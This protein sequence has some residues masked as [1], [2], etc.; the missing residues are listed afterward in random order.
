[1]ADLDRQ[2]AARRLGV[3]E[4]EVV[5]IRDE[6]DG[7]VITTLDGREY[8]A[9][10]DGYDQKLAYFKVG[11]QNTAFPIHIPVEEDA[12]EPA[13]DVDGDGV[14][15]GTVKQ[16]LEWVGTDRQ[17]AAQALAVER[18]K[19]ADARTTLIRDLEKLAA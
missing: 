13:V 3:P 17:R 6:A 9:L 2:S 19:E 8:I 18:E 16:I 1:M 4:A 14:P 5:A 11:P 7:P 12:D 15:D 10:G